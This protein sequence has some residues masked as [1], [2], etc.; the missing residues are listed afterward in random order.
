MI[1]RK[2]LPWLTAFLFMCALKSQAQTS[3]NYSATSTTNASLIA[4]KNGNTID[5]S[6]LPNLISNNA[7][8]ENALLAGIGFDLI[9]MGRRYTHF[10]AGGDGMVGLGLSNSPAGMISSIPNNNMLRFV[11]YPPTIGNDAPVLAAFWD[12]IRTARTGATVRSLVTGNAPNRCLVIQWNMVINSASVTNTNPADGVFQMRLYEGSGEIEYV[13]GQMKIGAG[14]GTVTASIGFTAGFTDNTFLGVT[15]LNTFAVSRLTADQTAMETL[16]NASTPGSITQLSSVVDGSR[17]RVSITPVTCVG[18]FTSSSITR[19]YAR[20]M[21]LNWTDTIHNKLGYLIYRSEAAPNNYT[22]YTSLPANATQYIAT[23]LNTNTRYFWKVIPYSEGNTQTV[24]DM[25]DST[26]CSMTGTYSIGPSGQFLNIRNAQDSLELWG[27]VGNTNWELNAGYNFSTETLPV[28]FNQLPP[29]HEFNN[30][31]TVRPATGVNISYTRLAFQPVFLIDSVKNIIIDGRAGGTGNTPALALESDGELIRIQ[32]GWNN[33][34]RYTELRSNSNSTTGPLVV[35]ASLGGGAHH[36]TIE[37]NLMHDRGNAFNLPTRFLIGLVSNNAENK[38]NTVRQNNFSNWSGL[39]MDIIGNGWRVDSNSFYA[40]R[41]ITMN[42]TSGFIHFRTGDQN[43]TDTLRGNFFGGTDALAAGNVMQLKT[44]S[45]FTGVKLAG[46]AWFRN[47]RFRRMKLETNSTPSA[48]NSVISLLQAGKEGGGGFPVNILAEQN[49]FGGSVLADSI[50]LLSTTNKPAKLNII[51]NLNDGTS[52]FK[53]NDFFNIR[54]L[55]TTNPDMSF[56]VFET[57]GFNATIDSNRISTTDHLLRIRHGGNGTLSGIYTYGNA[58]INYNTIT[59]ISGNRLTAGI[60]TQANN[61]QITNNLISHIKTVNGLTDFYFYSA[62]GISSFSSTLNISRNRIISIEDSSNT[63]SVGPA[64][65]FAKQCV[66]TIDRN[67]IDGLIQYPYSTIAKSM[68]AFEVEDD[69]STISNNMVRLGLDTAGNTVT[70]GLFTG[71]TNTPVSTSTLKHNSI[72][73][74]GTNASNANNG[75]AFCIFWLG[76]TMIQNNILCNERT[77]QSGNASA[78]YLNSSQAQG[79]YLDYNVYYHAPGLR[80]STDIDSFKVW[81]ASNRDPH[82]VFLFPNFVNRNA[83]SRLLDLHVFGQTPAERRGTYAYTNTEDFDGEIRDNLSPVDIGADAGNYTPV[84]LDAPTFNIVPLGNAPDTVSRYITIHITDSLAGLSAT[85]NNRPAIWYRKKYPTVTPW[86]TGFGTLVGGTVYSGDWQF[87]INHQLLNVSVNGADSIQYY[88]VAQDTATYPHFNLSI[89]PAEG[90]EHT[91]VTQQIT[92]P[93][94]PYI[95][96]INVGR[97]IIPAVVNIGLNQKYQS[98][99]GDGGLFEGLRTD[100]VQG[101]I[102]ARIVSHLSESGNWDLD[103]ILTRRHIKLTIVPG[104]DS[105]FNIRNNGDLNMEMIRLYNADNVTIDGSYN[106]SGRWLRFINTHSIPANGKATLALFRGTDS[107]L[108]KNA[109][110]QNNLESFNTQAIVTLQDNNCTDDRFINNVFSNASGLANPNTGFFTPFTGMPKRLLI[111][112]NHFVNITRYGVYMNGQADD[113]RVDSNHFY[114]NDPLPHASTEYIAINLTGST[115]QQQANGN[116]I[117]GSQPFCGGSVWQ[118]NADFNNF[119]GIQMGAQ[120]NNY[121]HIE[122]NTIRN[123]KTT[124]PDADN[125][126]P[127]VSYGMAIINHNAIGDSTITNSLDI[128]SISFTGI[129]FSNRKHIISNNLISGINCTSTVYYALVQGIWQTTDSSTV[130]RNNIIRNISSASGAQY[131]SS[132]ALCGISVLTHATLNEISQNQIFNLRCT[133]TVPVPIAGIHLNADNNAG[134]VSRNRIWNLTQPNSINGSIIGIYLQ[135]TGDW[136]VENN[137]ITLTNGS[138]AN[139][140]HIYGINDSTFL[141]T[142]N[143][144]FIEFN[145]ILI[146]GNQTGNS[147]S[148]GYRNSGSGK[149]ALFKNNLLMNART[150]GTGQ[151]GAVSIETATPATS[152]LP[153]S[154]NY[155]MYALKDTNTAFRWGFSSIQNIHA[156]RISTQT[157]QYSFAMQ[158]IKMP[159][160]RLFADSAKGDLDINVNDSICWYVNGRGLPLA[161]ISDDYGATN[162]RSTSTSSGAV[163]IGSDEFNTTTTPPVLRM[164]GNHVNGGTDSLYFNGNLTATITWSATGTLP[165]IS[166]ARFYAGTWPNDTTNNNTVTGA[167]YING[168]LLVNVTGGTGYSYDLKLFY[169]STMKGKVTNFGTVIMNKKQ[170]GTAGTWTDQHPT[171][172]NTTARTISAFNLTSFSEFTASDTLATLGAPTPM[173]DLVITGQSVNPASAPTGSSVNVVFTETNNGN[174]PASLAHKVNIYIS[175][176]NVLTPG[177]NGDQLLTQQ[178]ITATIAAGGNSGQF[179]KSAAIPCTVPAGTYFIF[180]VADGQAQVTESNET[181]NAVSVSL[182][183]TNGTVVPSV[184]IGYTGCPSTT[185]N[186]QATPVNGGTTPQYQWLVNNVISGTGVSFTLNNAVNGMVVKCVMTSSA[187]CATPQTANVTETINCISTAVPQ[188]DGMESFYIAPNPTK[189]LLRIQLKLANSRKMD[190]SLFDLN[191]KRV[192]FNMPVNVNGNVN[193]TIDM[194][195]LPN[196]VYIL[197]IGLNNQQFSVM[198]MKAE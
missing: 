175:A 178:D 197:R 29:C 154:A 105:V 24:L 146:G 89:S 93:A 21:Q 25:N 135:Q 77:Y 90:G 112:Q 117:G 167:R 132:P 186:F 27:I 149:S 63:N 169:D 160:G 10:I 3:A 11:N 97:Y 70:H 30:T 34:I 111:L 151:H 68:T 148:F 39:A 41:S 125:F 109:E 48:L 76:L 62:V 143:N 91:S 141:G 9:F 46:N 196:G 32:N 116:Y 165:Q 8:T 17:R 140:V 26:R 193:R 121:S 58:S 22:Y 18:N 7:T 13:Y 174:A 122:H 188:V 36:N 60:I 102:T 42:D 136:N 45:T 128:A 74:G 86:Q 155:N 195:S 95:Y 2:T 19:V 49:T 73:I 118:N 176:D 152:W 147:N 65:I 51:Y 184:T 161:N 83:P 1:F 108:V 181:N 144:H 88:F 159:A 94:T 162:V 131:S 47:N 113:I 15:N 187:V 150:G 80:F 168:Y 170:T 163:D 53:Q 56:S 101:D 99:T 40:T 98:L 145:S 85:G 33:T 191:G 115:S 69:Y 23:G 107:L 31:I 103:S 20:T 198:I 142:G 82:S 134:K 185:L 72:Y 44:G 123:I 87:F 79:A 43:Y 35:Q 171:L 61:R 64:A 96:R 104:F 129:Y 54:T 189:G 156:W 127:I 179:T 180:I 100:S 138:S 71:Y 120:S 37:Y 110:W 172:V 173:P 177:A 133:N 106:G 12:D 16:V 190:Y 14:S 130:I 6:A 183:V 52:I 194:T 153:N 5:F 59:N 75:G 158:E 126:F 57:W 182:T 38:L 81:K 124:H 139:P 4:D 157:D 192:L 92:A 66:N 28:R 55:A 114:W 119:Y 84:D 78:I 50:Y 67:H 137:Q 164:A 166:N